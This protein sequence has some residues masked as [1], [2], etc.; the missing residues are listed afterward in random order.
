MPASFFDAI[1]YTSAK[2]PPLVKTWAYWL[3]SSDLTLPSIVSDAH[4]P[5]SLFLSNILSARYLL[6]SGITADRITLCVVRLSVAFDASRPIC[7]RSLR[8]SGVT[9]VWRPLVWNALVV[10]TSTV[11]TCETFR[12]LLIL[13][14]ILL[15]IAPRS[16]M[17]LVVSLCC[18]SPSPSELSSRVTAPIV[19]VI[20]SSTVREDF[21]NL[22]FWGSHSCS[23][24]R[25]T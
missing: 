14:M 7:H 11:S 19:L 5:P 8:S 24:E 12:S 23:D 17:T 9:E 1:G 6:A 13:P 21:G 20:S 3:P 22:T 25:T 4:L 16:R 2:N 18:S 15:D 10:G